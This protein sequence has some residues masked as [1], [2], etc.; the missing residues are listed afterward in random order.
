MLAYVHI[1]YSTY[2]FLKESKGVES[3]PSPGPC[4]IE[5]NMV[6]GG[7]S[8]SPG[9]LPNEK[10]NMEMYDHKPDYSFYLQGTRIQNIV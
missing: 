4:D 10:W 8:H 9:F 1:E 2:Q 5:K 6:L 7:L 3:T